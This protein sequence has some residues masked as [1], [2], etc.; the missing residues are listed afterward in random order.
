MREKQK[1][2]T[3][4]NCACIINLLLF[5]VAIV[6]LIIKDDSLNGL[7]ILMVAFLGLSF[8]GELANRYSK[9]DRDKTK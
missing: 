4:L 5:P 6:I 9:D 8:F 7:L 3:W 1:Y 2:P